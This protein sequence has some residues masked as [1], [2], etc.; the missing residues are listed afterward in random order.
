MWMCATCMCAGMISASV[1]VCLF[2]CQCAYMCRAWS[3]A[4]VTH[5]V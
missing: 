5:A 2:K 1:Y 3:C 4:V